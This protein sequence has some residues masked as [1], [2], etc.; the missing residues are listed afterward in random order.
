MLIPVPQGANPSRSGFR[1][2]P[3]RDIDIG[4]GSV[5]LG[6][7]RLEPTSPKFRRDRFGDEGASA[8]RAD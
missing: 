5:H 8:P 1:R 7:R 6:Y 4:E 3:T 2:F